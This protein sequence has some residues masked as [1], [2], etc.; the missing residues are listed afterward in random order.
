MNTRNS[1]AKNK[2]KDSN[3]N[4]TRKREELSVSAVKT[5]KKGSGNCY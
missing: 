2:D 5:V 3:N 4:K 1:T